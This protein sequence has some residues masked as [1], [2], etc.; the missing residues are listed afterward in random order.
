VAELRAQWEREYRMK[1]LAEFEKTKREAMEAEMT[2][3]ES[4]ILKLKERPVP[5]EDESRAVLECYTTE[6][7]KLNC[8]D[9]VK[10]LRR[11]SRAAT[12]GRPLE[13]D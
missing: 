2:R 8:G 11:C 13:E 9:A 1:L 7:D 6:K 12:W 5:C 4:K 10:A 3:L